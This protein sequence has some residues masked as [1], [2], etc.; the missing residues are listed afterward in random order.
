MLLGRGRVDL[1]IRR[2]HHIV[3]LLGMLHYNLAVAQQTMRAVAASLVMQLRRQ[4][5]GRA[6]RRD[7]SPCS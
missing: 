3:Q 7:D 6:A 1:A 2:V 5:P 4:L